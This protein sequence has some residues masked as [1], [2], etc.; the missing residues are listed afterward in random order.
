MFISRRHVI[1]HYH[2][3]KNAGSSV[4][5]ALRSAFGSTWSR[6]EGTHPNDIQSRAQLSSFLQANPTVQAVS[7]H[8]ARPPLPFRSCHPIVFIRHPLLRAASAYRFIRADPVQAQ[9]GWAQQHSLA[10]FFDRCADEHRGLGR[11]ISNYQVFHLSSASAR[12]FAD[13]HVSETHVTEAR[14]LLRSWGFVGIVERYEQSLR[15]YQRRYGRYFSNLV[16]PITHENRTAV[17]DP[18]VALMIEKV[19]QQLPDATYARFMELNQADFALYEWADVW[20]TSG[21]RRP[22]KTLY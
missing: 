8:L 9:H 3:F 6:F 13:I 21:L 4:Y 16:L 18:S 14:R 5:A 10:G 1:V 20:N 12:D 19:R 22:F 15:E 11:V 2:I 7:S 17:A